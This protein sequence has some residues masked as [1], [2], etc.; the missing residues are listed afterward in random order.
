MQTIGLD[1]GGA[2]LKAASSDGNAASLAFELWR[3][4]GQLPQELNRLLSQFSSGDR[5]AV[6]MTAELAD[7]FPTKA[8][9]VAAVL[10]AVAAVAGPRPIL[11]WQTT[12][13]FAPLEQAVATPLQTA[14][15]NWHALA[16]WAG[17]HCPDGNALLLDIG[18][19]TTDLIPIVNGLPAARGQT[20]P[21]RLLSGEL[22]Y[23]GVRRTPLCALRRTVD[24]QAGV[25]RVAAEF[26][27][28]T[29]DVYL[30][31]DRVPEDA[32]DT[33]TADGRPATRSAAHNRL[34]HMLCGDGTELSPDDAL[35]IAG[36][37]AETQLDLLSQAVSQVLENIS[38]LSAVVIS[39]SG[40]FL[41]RQLVESHPLLRQI[42]PID[43]GELLSPAAANAACA[44]AV[45]RL[46]MKESV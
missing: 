18:S 2:N 9:G 43:L 22:V 33:D 11:V 5:L 16:S 8:E 12:G 35:A 37:F 44:Y 1:I 26:F 24:W 25:C 46:A 39:G 7:C 31:L 38:R 29:L 30:L 15:A 14:A 13:R 21:Q 23:T 19:T 42:R 36:Q 27:A 20:D 40:S 10:G 17:P 34:A 6:T 4:P 45:A 32:G 41:A 28:T 3:A